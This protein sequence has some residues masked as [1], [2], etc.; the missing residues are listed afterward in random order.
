M[1]RSKKMTR[2]AADGQLADI[3]GLFEDAYS[4]YEERRRDREIENAAFYRGQHYIDSGIGGQSQ[5]VEDEAMETQNLVRSII[6]AAVASRLRQMPQIAIASL[7]GDV[8]ARARAKASEGLCQAFLHNGV[9]DWEEHERCA[10]WAEQCGLGYVKWYW[11]P[12]A[13]RQLPREDPDAF[14]D[15]AE[16][17]SEPDAGFEEDVTETDPFGEPVEE[18]LA[19]GDIRTMF[20]PSSD[21]LPN[22]DARSWKEVRHFFHV[23]LMPVGQI[24][25]LWPKDMWGKDLTAGDLDTGANAYGGIQGQMREVQQ[26]DE[27]IGTSTHEIDNE[28]AQLVEFWELPTRKYKN[29]RFAVFSGSRLIWVGP[30]WLTPKRVPFVPFFGGNK[31]PSSL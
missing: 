15:E 6:N 19:E 9:I 13:G 21:G 30:N 3:E 16:K 24:L 4:A 11:D 17:A 28:L 10:S 23:R 25:D 22:P 14:W 20:V 7:R 5:L 27:G 1:Q 12:K 29:G 31:V 2:K 18:Q 8:K 26:D